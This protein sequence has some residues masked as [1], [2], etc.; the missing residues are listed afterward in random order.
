MGPC[1]SKNHKNAKSEEKG[2]VKH[3]AAA[4]NR[5]SEDEIK[6]AELKSR[7]NKLQEYRRK[8]ESQKSE[9]HLKA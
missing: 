4:N 1:I 5:V 7:I 6:L 2:I 9:Q 3:R 8:I